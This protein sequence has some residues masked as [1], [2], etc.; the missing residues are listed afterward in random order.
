M[1]GL[2][3]RDV[4]PE[5][6]AAVA[7]DHAIAMRRRWQRDNRQ[8]PTLTPREALAALKCEAWFVWTAAHNSARGVVLSDVDLA[9]LTLAAR[10][11]YRIASE[12]GV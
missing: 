8:P 6:R 2:D 1:S 3:L 9:R 12:A 11:I 10:F 4:E 7:E 5:R